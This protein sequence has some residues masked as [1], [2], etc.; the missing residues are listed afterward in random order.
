[1]YNISK[2]KLK[3]VIILHVYSGKQLYT[4]L[5]IDDEILSDGEIRREDYMIGYIVITLLAE[6]LKGREHHRYR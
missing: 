1:M 2:S 4:I 5:C 6:W 3:T